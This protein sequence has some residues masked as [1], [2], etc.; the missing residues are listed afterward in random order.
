MSS[1]IFETFD[2]DNVS[3]GTAP[4]DVVHRDG[5]YHRA[6]HVFV[7]NSEGELLLQKRAPNKDV[8]PDR[9]DLSV[10]EHAH[11]G[12]V[13]FETALRGL[14]EELGL[15]ASIKLAAD[16]HLNQFKYPAIGVKD[17]EFVQ[18]FTCMH[19][20]PFEMDNVEVVDTR[21]ISLEDLANEVASQ[22][23]SLT[24]WFLRDLELLGYI[25]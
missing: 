20:G 24:P 17:F 2:H 5:L 23:E 18:T 3:I 12:E 8:C 21:L 15:A 25:P 13:P 7:F 22:P 10:A 1:E 4:R 9:W 11:P 14:E 19:D 6:T 16:F